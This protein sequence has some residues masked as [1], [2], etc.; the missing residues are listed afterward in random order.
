VERAKCF[1]APTCLVELDV[2]ADHVFGGQPRLDLFNWSWHFFYFPKM[3]TVADRYAS[4][5]LDLY[6]KIKKSFALIVHKFF[7][8]LDLGFAFL[9]NV[10]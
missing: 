9:D 7:Y 1:V 6:C 5:E 10:F 2:G 4:S 8:E 3:V